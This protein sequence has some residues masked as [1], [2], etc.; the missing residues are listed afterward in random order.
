MALPQINLT[1]NVTDS[2]ALRHTKAGHPVMNL[3]VA[4]NERKKDDS[5]KWVDGRTVFLDVTVWGD[6]AEAAAELVDKGTEVTVIGRLS[7]KEYT[8]K[9]GNLRKQLT[10]DADTLACTVGRGGK[11]KAASTQSFDE[12]P[13]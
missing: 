11:P 7:E 3:R 5:G 6:K 4:C 1:G 8:D 13:F 2:P 12:E 10:I 9:D